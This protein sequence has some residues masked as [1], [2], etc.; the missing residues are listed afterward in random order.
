[1]EQNQPQPPVF[2]QQPEQQ[3]APQYDYGK[4]MMPFWTAVKTC[5]HKYFD[6][7]GRARRSE[8]WWF[9]L[10]VTIVGTVWSL[11]C[12]FGFIG[13]LMS[14]DFDDTSIL[15]SSYYWVFLLVLGV[16]LLLF[17]I[18][19]YSAMTRRLHD[20][21]HSG[22]WV[23]AMIILGLCYYA[24]YMI[25]FIPYLT[26]MDVEDLATNNLPVML[27]VMAVICLAALVLG[28]VIL[29]YAITDSHREE[30]K[31]GPSPKYQ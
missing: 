31:Y 5:W 26:S 7:T 19:Q 6:F 12:V 3:P 8:Y 14:S 20:T 13:F 29:V 23:V 4:P 9:V 28:I 27:P 24:A 15:T 17:V 22:W 11:L 30:N 25:M 21:G 2:N 1:M 10:F 16:P 18:P